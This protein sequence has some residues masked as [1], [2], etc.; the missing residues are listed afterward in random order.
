MALDCKDEIPIELNQS[1]AEETSVRVA[2]IRYQQQ[3]ELAIINIFRIV[4]WLLIFYRF[5]TNKRDPVALLLV[6]SNFIA[7]FKLFGRANFYAKP[8]RRELE[9]NPNKQVYITNENKPFSFAYSLY[10]EF[11]EPNI[12]F[13]R[14][15]FMVKEIESKEN[16]DSLKYYSSYK[17]VIMEVG[18]EKIFRHAINLKATLKDYSHDLVLSS[19]FG[20]MRK[21][22]PHCSSY[23]MTTK[24]R[25]LDYLL[26]PNFAAGKSFL[27]LINFSSPYNT[28]LICAYAFSALIMA[29]RESYILNDHEFRLNLEGY[30]FNT[31]PYCNLWNNCI[32]TQIMR[33]IHFNPLNNELVTVL[34][35]IKYGEDILREL[36]QKKFDDDPE[37]QGKNFDYLVKIGFF[38]FTPAEQ[39]REHKNLGTL[40]TYPEYPTGFQ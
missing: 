22:L 25:L 40:Q 19:K 34:N 36:R 1:E 9:E 33:K 13:D 16:D 7:L 23:E 3:F 15:E 18:Q 11:I 35:Q 30:D 28:L 31:L 32:S 10:C 2:P 12:Y 6:F 20:T 24:V 26:F 5:D 39:T 14:K 29:V 27:A 37:K 17:T 38:T 8:I 4:S 21:M